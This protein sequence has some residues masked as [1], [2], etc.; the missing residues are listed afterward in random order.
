MATKLTIIIEETSDD[1]IYSGGWPQKATKT[2]VSEY[3]EAATWSSLILDMVD[4]CAGAG[5]VSIKEKI[6]FLGVVTSDRDEEYT[7]EDF[8]D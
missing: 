8:N 4:A 5:Y 6:R 2:F 3:A 1:P 7:V